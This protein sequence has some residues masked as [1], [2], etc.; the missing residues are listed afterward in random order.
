[1]K[2]SRLFEN[3]RGMSMACGEATACA[4]A[5]EAVSH[6]KARPS[7]VSPRLTRTQKRLRG[8]SGDRSCRM[9]TVLRETCES[10]LR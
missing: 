2:S 6:I 10:P 9:S 5:G 8:L 7:S 3:Q 4:I 1:M